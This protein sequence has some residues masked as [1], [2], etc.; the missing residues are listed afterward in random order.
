MGIIR[1]RIE[2]LGQRVEIKYDRV[3]I[4]WWDDDN[5]R[6]LHLGSGAESEEKTLIL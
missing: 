6:V 1:A 2:F 3:A 4:G 5:D